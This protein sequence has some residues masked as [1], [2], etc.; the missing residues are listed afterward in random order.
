MNYFKQVIICFCLVLFLI[1]FS[2]SAQSSFRIFPYLQVADGNL[3][4]IRW[5]SAG[6]HSSS[7]LVKDDTGNILFSGNITGIKQSDLYYTAL[8][9]NETIPGLEGQ[10]WIGGEEYFRF[11]SKFRVP[12]DTQIGY[13]VTLNGEKFTGS[14]RSAPD[15]KSWEKV[16]IVALSDSET[17]PRGRVTNRAWYPGQPLFRPFSIPAL[18]K[19]KFGTTVEQ[20]FEIPNYFLT[21]KAGYAENLK[22]LKT[23]EPD[24]ILMPGD[25]VQ[26]GGYMP[27]WDEF[28]RHNAGEFDQI[29]TR[30]P[31]IP[32]LGNWE[33]FGALNGGYGVNEKGQFN[34]VVGRSRFHSFF[35]L[36]F[37]DQLQ[38]HRQSYYRTDYGPVTILT[39]DSTNGTPDE[40]RS[41]YPDGQKL[42]GKEFSGP[43]TDTQENFTQSQ[44]DAARGKDLSGFGPGSA[45]YEWLVA[46]L[47]EAKELG[48]LVFVQFHHIPYSSGEHG[49][50]M[51]HELSTGQG[52][53]PMR[54][55]HPVFEEYGVIAV[56]SGH[57]E[58]FERS[59]VDT[60]GDGKGVLYYDV[61][62][63]GDGLRGVKRDWLG[64]PLLPLDY[65]S[66]SKWTA[67]QKSA[68]QWN[69]S[70]PF[71]ILTDGGK[72]YGHLEINISKIKDGTKT[73]AQI[74]F[75]PVYVFPVLNSSYELIRT[76][77]R[78]YDDRVKVL[79]ELAEEIPEPIFKEKII[80]GLN[81]SGEVS[82]TLADYLEGEVSADWKVEFSRS[83]KYDCSDLQGSENELLITDSKGNS[84]KKV[85]LVEVKDLLPPT[86]STKLPAL[87]FD[88]VKG[89]LTLNPEDFVESLTDNCS[90]QSLQ[91]SKSKITCDDYELP[92]EVVLTAKDQSGNTVTKTVTFSVNPF[93]SKKI[94][95]SPESGSTFFEGEVV[96]IR[97]GE[98]F[99]FVVS[100]WYRN[101]ELLPELKGKAIAVE[102]PGMYW[103]ELFPEGGGCLVESKKTEIR[104]TSLPFGELKESV[105]LILGPEG[106]ADLKPSDI[107]VTWPLSDPNL[108]ITLQQSS[109]TC[110][111][112]GEKIIGVV[113]KSSSG[114]TWERTIQV[115]VKDTTAPILKP[116]NL[117]LGL[118]VTVGSVSLNPDLILDSA[119]DICGIKEITLDR[120]AFGCE[121]LGK[122]IVV[123][124]RAVDP[125]GNVAEAITE[126][127][128]KRIE[129][130]PVLLQGV[131]E[132]CSGEEA[133]LELSSNT[134]FEVIRWRRNGVE[135]PDQRAK[136]LTTKEPG[137]YHVVIRYSGG[138]LSESNTFEVKVNPLPEGEIEVDGNILRAPEGN[139][140]YQWF[141][142]GQAISSATS[143]TLTVDQ[144]GEYEVELTSP[145]GCSARLEPVTLTISGIGTPL[146]RKA[147][148]LKIYPNP[149]RERVSLEFDGEFAENQEFELKLVDANGKDV[150]RMV[151]FNLIGSQTIELFLNDL[152]P[153]TYLVWV[154]GSRQQS[155]FGKLVIQ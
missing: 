31:I 148:A 44:Y 99:G 17:E 47:K 107:F 65:N 3:V 7:V 14:F 6:N 8:E 126:V 120:Q 64:N 128:I 46:N 85:V 87:N 54:V 55:L 5:F 53:T 28:W 105:E 108:T 84:W 74:E 60:N 33:T 109:F 145:Q 27:G 63:A 26:G 40:K 136:T 93:E 147:Q 71:P 22:I 132:I 41:D 42:K 106:K 115:K 30:I 18:W 29:I 13:E 94:S 98:E 146:A 9:R 83:P 134:A 80:V 130:S 62:V 2:V 123:K 101:G 137:V 102:L 82:T 125:S 112:L 113:I 154:L 121:D 119:T 131:E 86:L 50:P 155:F 49:V 153:G 77:R 122:T 15:P 95:I 140:T 151:N 116:K 73:F 138:C 38:K 34:P 78:V 32:A 45:Q 37:G 72:H 23:R 20:G 57:D 81:Q 61:G 100:G 142:N 135:I 59:F 24:L 52:G 51:N 114:Q 111:D 118:D 133:L 43:G 10:N 141:R 103:A 150:S 48:H 66:F 92:Q 143:R 152:A 35:E 36:D 58:I 124:I 91:L 21:E 97:L 25:L 19:E 129:P 1:P 96:E 90:I 12:F 16:R 56:L 88:L 69:T 79:V 149:A 117:N 39:L 11:D 139:F 67:D 75:D 104:F 70:G 4:Q 127:T 110:A 89:E 68:E 76:E 144:M